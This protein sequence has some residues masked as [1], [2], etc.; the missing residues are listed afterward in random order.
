MTVPKL[1]LI[2]MGEKMI[3]PRD[4]KRIQSGSTSVLV[5]GSP[6]T[7]CVCSVPFA[8]CPKWICAHSP[9]TR[10]FSS[11]PCLPV[12]VL[13]PAQFFLTYSHRRL[14]S[15]REVLNKDYKNQIFC[16]Q[17]HDPYFL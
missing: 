4:D 11:V 15:Y 12:P 10:A 8:P 6:V 16:R 17:D 13:V 5:P 1:V 9:L 2:S 3:G 7:L 14:I